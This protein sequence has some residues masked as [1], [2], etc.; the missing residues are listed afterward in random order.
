MKKGTWQSKLTKK[1]LAHLREHGITTLRDFVECRTKQLEM[2]TMGI[3][4]HP[5]IN[6][7]P[8]WDCRMIA[9]KL[10]VCQ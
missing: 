1:E 9:E 5:G 8:C 7:E 3:A 10:G 6:Q 4:L 2:K